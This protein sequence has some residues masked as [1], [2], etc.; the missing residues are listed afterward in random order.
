MKFSK[1]LILIALSYFTSLSD[2]A[3]LKSSSNNN[4]NNKAYLK[5]GERCENFKT[6]KKCN[7]E[8]ICVVT[9]AEVGADKKLTWVMT[10]QKKN[11]DFFTSNKYC[12]EF[13]PDRN[14]DPIRVKCANEKQSCQID[15]ASKI[16]I[17]NFAVTTSNLGKK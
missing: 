1:T 3:L 5:K 2:S 9:D 8:E 17:C 11:I 14:L 15:S 12:S 6:D 10:C 13:G 16:G 7:G 4:N